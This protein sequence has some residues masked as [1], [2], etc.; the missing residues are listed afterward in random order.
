MSTSKEQLK[1]LDAMVAKKDGGLTEAGKYAIIA[2]AVIQTGV[3]L[4]SIGITAFKKT[5]FDKTLPITEGV[6]GVKEKIDFANN[7][8]T[9]S[10]KAH[11]W[12]FK[13]LDK[14]NKS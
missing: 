6:K 8:N 14:M 7:F 5:F 2:T 11:D 12:A 3:E 4:G 1:K 10:S 9:L 13:M